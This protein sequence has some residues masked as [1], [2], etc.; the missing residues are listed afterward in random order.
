MVVKTGVSL[1]DETYQE[2]TRLARILGY[3]SISQAVRDAVNLFITANRWATTSLPL[4]G[5]IQALAEE[6]S[7]PILLSKIKSPPAVSINLLPVG[8]GYTLIIVVV[9]GE[10]GE[11]KRLYSL[12]SST[13]GV[14]AVTASLL[15]LAAQPGGREHPSAPGTGT[16]RQRGR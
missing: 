10:P 8:E 12:L 2:L 11:I 9:R 1:P 6:K 16:P 7:L 13:P 15:P 4:A 3:N 14:S 5:S